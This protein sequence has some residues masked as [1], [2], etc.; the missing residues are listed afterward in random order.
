MVLGDVLKALAITWRDFMDVSETH[1]GILE[2]KIYESPADESRA[3]E[4]WANCNAWL[5]V[6]KLINIHVDVSKE[7]IFRL[8]ELIDEDETPR[9]WLD[10]TVEEYEKLASLVQED[11]VKPTANLS[12]LMYKSVGIRDSRQS[13][14]LGTSLWRLRY[15]YVCFVRPSGA[16]CGVWLIRLKLGA[17]DFSPSATVTI[18]RRFRSWVSSVAS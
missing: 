6:E 2:D 7:L 5:K 18:I 9:N 17:I 10:G 15:V 12:D 16:L 1:V 11:L 8:A 13:L 3:S 4:I 14:Q